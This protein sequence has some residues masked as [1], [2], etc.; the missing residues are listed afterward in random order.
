MIVS[1]LRLDRARVRAHVVDAND[2]L[3]A[4]AEAEHG[5]VLEEAARG[6]WPTAI[7]AALA[8]TIG[9]AVPLLVIL[10][11][12]PALRGAVTFVAVALALCL[13]SVVVAALGGADIWRTAARTVAIGVATMLLTLLGGSL[14]E[15]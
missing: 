2:A 7:L 8:F 15:V 11:T 6:V 4:H 9:S 3:A 14:F 10:L 13:T 1:G 12:P 5:I